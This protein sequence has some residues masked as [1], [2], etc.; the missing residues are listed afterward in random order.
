MKPR[1]LYILRVTLRPRKYISI[2][3]FLSK[4]KSSE[5][6]MLKEKAVETLLI[7]LRFPNP[8]SQQ[9]VQNPEEGNGYTAGVIRVHRIFDAID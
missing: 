5:S 1:A 3:T 2:I 8:V 9:I 6:H 4:Y 7:S